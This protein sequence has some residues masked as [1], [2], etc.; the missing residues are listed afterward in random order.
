MGKGKDGKKKNKEA[1]E[2]VLVNRGIDD[3]NYGNPD[4]PSKILLHVPKEELKPTLKDKHEEILEK[5]PEISRGVYNDD[6]IEQNL[7]SLG[8]AIRNEDEADKKDIIQKL[9]EIN[10]EGMKKVKID[11]TKN[12]IVTYDKHAKVEPVEEEIDT[13][14]FNKPKGSNNA[15]VLDDRKLD[16]IFKKAKINAKVTEYNEFG[17]PKD[18]NPEVLKYVTNKEF[19]EGVDIFIPAPGYN[20]MIQENRF[21]IDIKPE[22]MNEEYKEVYDAMKSDNEEGA[23]EGGLEDDFILLANE[24]EKPIQIEK[25]EVVLTEYKKEKY[26]PSYKYITKEEKEFLDKQFSSTYEKQYKDDDGDQQVKPKNLVTKEIF[27]DAINELIPKKKEL[28][29]RFED[30]EE[31]EDYEDYDSEDEDEA[32][33]LKEEEYDELEED[34]EGECQEFNINKNIRVE[35]RGNNKDFDQ[36]RKKPRQKYMQEE[37]TLKEF[38]EILH[39]K[40]FV[41]KTIELY[42]NKPEEGDN[43]D[44]I[45]YPEYYIEKKLDI[46]SQH[47]RIG[48]L[49]KTISAQD[50][51][52]LLK[53]KNKSNK[54]KEAAS[55]TVG[56]VKTPT[57]I[58]DDENKTEKKL[59]KTL[60]KQE[61]KEKRKQKKELKVAFQVLLYI[62]F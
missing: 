38:D 4:A 7:K 59:R 11:F 45:P 44:Q 3:P 22:E 54:P 46:T 37:M 1:L 32:E 20:E 8:I 16:Q 28:T 61:N 26:V 12:S 55:E 31:Y 58:K 18:I 48:N 57:E 62:I 51:S 23:E 60:I 40:G 42:D 29:K 41:E 56:T 24:G 10:V 9:N 21:D 52:K 39:N 43:D 35:S 13:T 19:V 14:S 53:Q 34:D 27:E 17:L 15:E 2:F 5:I 25:D 36:E 6:Y 30:E 47:G 50:E 49:P 33:E